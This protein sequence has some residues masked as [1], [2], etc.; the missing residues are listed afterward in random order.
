MARK[1]IKGVRIPVKLPWKGATN[2]DDQFVSMK[3]PVAAWLGIDKANPND[4]VY[5]VK[6]QKK[7]K[8]GEKVS[9]TTTIKRRRRPGYRQRSIRLEFGKNRQ[10]NPLKKSIAGVSVASVQFP[11]TKSTSINDV[12]NYFSSGKGKSLGVKRIVDVN[13]GQGYSII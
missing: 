6:A 3:E 5:E 7:D 10:G 8:A 11:I 1:G 2:N 12:Y 13:S 4:L 9:G